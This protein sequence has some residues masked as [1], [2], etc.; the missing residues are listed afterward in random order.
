MVSYSLSS[1]WCVAGTENF[2]MIM[3]IN[4]DC[5]M[6]YGF[7][8]LFFARVIP[9]I[10]LKALGFHPFVTTLSGIWNM[11]RKSLFEDDYYRLTGRE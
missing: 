9:E 1:G 7:H 8:F 11:V 6:G 2:A 3:A 4:S 5:H 10:I